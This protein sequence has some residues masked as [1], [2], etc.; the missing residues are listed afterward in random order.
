MPPALPGHEQDVEERRFKGCQVLPSERRYRVM[1]GVGVG[2]PHQ[3]V[4]LRRRVTG[5]RI[6]GAR[7]IALADHCRPIG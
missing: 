1:V 4:Q 6:N 2:G 7:Q 5:I 3:K